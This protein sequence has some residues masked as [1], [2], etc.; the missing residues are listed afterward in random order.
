[1]ASVPLLAV[2]ERLGRHVSWEMGQAAGGSPAETDTEKTAGGVMGDGKRAY[3]DVADYQRLEKEVER[4]KERCKIWKARCD[5][6]TDTLHV[7][8]M[9]SRLEGKGSFGSSPYWCPS[10]I[11]WHTAHED[12]AEEKPF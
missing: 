7:V 6:L 8:G 9:W 12:W 5:V 3:V 4:L 1:M 11:A 10:C 2:S